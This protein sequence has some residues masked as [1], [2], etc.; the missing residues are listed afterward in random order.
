[1][2]NVLRLLERK[3]MAWAGIGL[4][5]TFFLAA[6]EYMLALILVLFLYVLK[7]VPA[8]KFPSG[9]VLDV[10]HISPVLV[11]IIMAAIGG[12]RALFQLTSRHALHAMLELVRGRLKIVQGYRMLLRKGEHPVSQSQINMVMNEYIPKASDFVYFAVELAS[13]LCLSFFLLLGM[14]F[15]AWK[16]SLLGIACLGGFSLLLHKLNRD[17]KREAAHVPRERNVLERSLVRIC[18]NWLLIRVMRIEERE[19]LSFIDSSLNYFRHSKRAFFYRNLAI[20]LPALFGIFSMALIVGMNIGY[21]HTSAVELVGFVYLFQAFSRNLMPIAEKIG[22][23]SL[24]RPQFDVAVRIISDLPA[25]EM[26]IA[27]EPGKRFRLFETWGE[28]RNGAAI[29]SPSPGPLPDSA[30]KPPDIILTRLSFTWPDQ[31]KPVIA[32]LSLRIPPGD[33]FGIIG[34]NGCGKSTLL[35]LILGILTPVAGEVLVNGVRGGVLGRKDI[36]VGY[37]CDDHFLVHGSIRE[38]L[39]YGNERGAGEAEIRDALRLVRL[40]SLVDSLPGGCD[41]PIQ[42]NEEGLSS[43]EKQRLA[44]ARAFLRRPTL[45]ILDEASANLDRE[46]EAVLAEILNDLSGRCTTI[47]VSHKPGILRG[48]ERVFKM[49]GTFN[50]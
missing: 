10:R 20:V 31:A 16:E 39:L 11:I 42:E 34:P 3:G 13:D 9:F 32:D 47:I 43:G 38:N 33:R 40:E 30:P 49:G 48:A 46:A 44:L 35:G 7:L 26:A 1:M 24:Y 41:Y 12:L 25:G 19:Y 37:V 21:F 2:R 36:T 8:A 15:L 22:L 29:P 27:I 50:G 23:L 6:S 5:S 14:L 45:L 4:G 18:R 17:L 28:R